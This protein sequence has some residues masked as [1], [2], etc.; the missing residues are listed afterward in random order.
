MKKNVINLTPENVIRFQLLQYSKYHSWKN[1]RNLLICEEYKNCRK[2]RRQFKYPKFKGKPIMKKMLSEENLKLQKSVTLIMRYSFENNEIFDVLL[3]RNIEDKYLAICKYEKQQII[4]YHKIVYG[5]CYTS[6]IRC[7]SFVFTSYNKDNEREYFDKIEKYQL[8]R[9]KRSHDYNHIYID[10]NVNNGLCLFPN[11]EDV[12]CLWRKIKPKYYYCPIVIK[13]EYCC[14]ACSLLMCVK[15]GKFC[16]FDPNGYTKSL[17]K[18]HNNIKSRA[19][20]QILLSQWTNKICVILGLK[21]SI[22]YSLFC[23]KHYSIHETSDGTK[24]GWCVGWAVGFACIVNHSRSKPQ[25]ILKK[26]MV[27]TREQRINFV[28]IVIIELFSLL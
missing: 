2:E 21:K 6:C 17:Y 12:A 16:W 25:K 14:H 18:K 20:I 22:Y 19:N 5:F 11:P 28:S 10:I 27:M 24:G 4:N 13:S 9:S 23:T 7:V 26:F 3:K 15:T 8:K 1:I